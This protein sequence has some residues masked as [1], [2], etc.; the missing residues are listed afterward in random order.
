MKKLVL[1]A[2]VALV[3]AGIGATAMAEGWRHKHHGKHEGDG[4]GGHM[5]RMMQMIDVNGDG[6]IGDDEA[7][8]AAEHMF[9]RLDQNGNGELT[10]E[11]ATTPPMAMMGKHGMGMGMEGP[12]GKRHGGWRAWWNGN[13]NAPPPPPPAAAGQQGGLQPPPQIQYPPMPAQPPGQQVQGQ[14]GAGPQG[15]MAARFA[16]MQER[17]KARFAEMDA[18]KNGVVT[19]VEFM[20]AAKARFQASDADKDG[21]VTPWEYRSQMWP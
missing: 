17:M 20:N 11:E 13:D 15:P 21:K 7:A 4:R 14:P 5:M 16:Q 9:N 8:A 2:T 10:L 3:T 19:K 12:G 6:V 18:D 1:L